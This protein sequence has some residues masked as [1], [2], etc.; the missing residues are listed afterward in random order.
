V[1]ALR[2]VPSLSVCDERTLLAIVGDAANLFWPAG[3]AVFERGTPSDGLY[4]V[5][6][7]GVRVLED[8]RELAA[9]GPGDYFGEFSLLLGSDH[10]HHVEATEDSELMVV[11]K[12][13]FDALLAENPELAEG[14]R[15]RAEERMRANVGAAPAA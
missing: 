7:G 15:R 2:A 10:Q 6:S 12:E 9:L 4:I 8:G 1:K 11:P 5:V 13:R 14:I 3:S